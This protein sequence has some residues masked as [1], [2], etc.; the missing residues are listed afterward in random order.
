MSESK[1]QVEIADPV[2]QQGALGDGDAAGEISGETEQKCASDGQLSQRQALVDLYH[3]TNGEGWTNSENWCT[4]AP[5]D[6]WFGVT[7]NDSGEVV[8]LQLRNNNICGGCLGAVM[9]DD[10]RW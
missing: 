8:Q 10:V 2:G 6:T 9:N 3:A 4:D 5:I 1:I 7:C